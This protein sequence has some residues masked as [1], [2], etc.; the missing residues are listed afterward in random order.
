[1]QPD[2]LTLLVLSGFP[3]G[4]MNSLAG[5]GYFV[6]LPALI[7]TGVPSVQANASS[8]VALY[9]GGL[10]GTWA[11]RDGLAPVGG[12]PLKW[13]GLV[14]AVGGLTDALLLLWTPSRTFDIVVPWLLLLAT[15]LLA[16]G[17]QLGEVRLTRAISES[18][19]ARRPSS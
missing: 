3:A 18:G 4:A 16:F 6:S 11:Y 7:A 8:T 19:C 1:M 17:K 12:V 15:M 9:P 10:A 2:H 5:G 14:T 13:L